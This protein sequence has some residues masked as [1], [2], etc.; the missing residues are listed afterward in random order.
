MSNLGS[1]EIAPGSKIAQNSDGFPHADTFMIETDLAPGRAILLSG[2]SPRPWDVR[3]GYMLSGATLVPQGDDLSKIVFRIEL[4]DP[5]DYQPWLA[6]S[7]KYL[8]KAVRY[9]PGSIQPRALGI[10]HPVISASPI[11]VTQVVVEDVT[12]LV[13]DE[14][15]IWSCEVHFIQYRKPMLALG[16]PDAAIPAAQT[17]EPSVDDKLASELANKV[18]TLTNLAG[19]L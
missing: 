16:K 14:D 1:L 7:A 9:K 2:N 8:D 15:G 12:A 13:Q 5:A 17:A 3:K 18:N 11:S 19:S 10:Y 6:F 4:W